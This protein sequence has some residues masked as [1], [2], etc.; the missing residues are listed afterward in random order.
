MCSKSDIFNYDH[1][2][3]LDDGVD[4]PFSMDTKDFDFGAQYG[5]VYF[6]NLLTSGQEAEVYY[7]IDQG[8]NYTQLA[9]VTAGISLHKTK[10]FLNISCQQ[11]RFR[12]AGVGGGF[13][14]AS[15]GFSYSIDSEF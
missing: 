1:V 7:S 6:V 8:N 2:T 10:V 14:L 11:I 15:L 3:A 4:I 13:K 9:S 5:R 12:V